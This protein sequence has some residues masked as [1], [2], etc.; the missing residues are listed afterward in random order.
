MSQIRA[1]RGE[2]V[3]TLSG[4]Q[5]VVEIREEGLGRFVI[6]A[7]ARLAIWRTLESLSIP[8]TLGHPPPGVGGS[9]HFIEITS[10]GAAVSV[11]WWRSPPPGWESLEGVFDTLAAAAPKEI[12]HRY[13]FGRGGE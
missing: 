3:L 13:D 1:R 9:S 11:Q 10:G 6:D 2:T 7:A 4:S 12:R 5:L 8:L